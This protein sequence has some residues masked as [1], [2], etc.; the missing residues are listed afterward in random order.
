MA[1][2]MTSSIAEVAAL[3]LYWLSR[4]RGAVRHVT[5]D[6]PGQAPGALSCDWRAADVRVVWLTEHGPTEA[7]LAEVLQRG[8]TVVRGGQVR[9]ASDTRELASVSEHLAR[10]H[11]HRP[12]KAYV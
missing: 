4:G 9:S 3:W 5:T 11:T 10:A 8:L 2:W 12:R 6:S 1:R 7:S